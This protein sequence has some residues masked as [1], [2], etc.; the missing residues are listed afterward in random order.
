MKVRLRGDWARTWPKKCLKIFFDK[1]T[2]FEGQDRINLN[3]GWRDP[4]FVR[5]PLAYQ[6]YAACGVPASRSRMG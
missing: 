3:S 1:Q 6:I 5:E 2:L 4:A